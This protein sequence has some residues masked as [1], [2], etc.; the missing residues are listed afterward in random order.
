MRLR[1]V[2]PDDV[3][4]YV[5]M[6][7]DPVMMKELGGPVPR[8]DI[9]DKVRRDAEE[10]AADTSWIKMIVPDPGRPEV[11][12]GSVCVWSHDQDEK[13]FSEIGW[14]VLPEFQGRGI[15]KLATR[16]LLERAGEDGR[17]GEIHAFPA[18]GNAA[19]NG[20]CAALGFRLLGETDVDFAGRIIHS[21]HWMIDPRS[22]PPKS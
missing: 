15:G 18:T 22:D 7:C 10:A 20:I 16:I 8:D 14:M 21:N 17:W 9:E 5:R 19:S 1:N 2:T 4:A 11:V 13:P 6:R 12:A 3:D